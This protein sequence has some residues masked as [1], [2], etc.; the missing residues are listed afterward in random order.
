VQLHHFIFFL[1][2]P[3]LACAPSSDLSQAIKRLDQADL[4]INSRQNQF[5]RK[6]EDLSNSVLVLQDRVETLKVALER[7]PLHETTTAPVAAAHPKPQPARSGARPGSARQ[8]DAFLPEAAKTAKLPTIKLTNKDLARMDQIV[9]PA[10]VP[11]A[12]TS[13]SPTPSKVTSEDLKAAEEYNGAYVVFEQEKYAE[14]IERFERFTK[15]YP[16][17]SYADNAVFWVGEAYFR[18]A[19]YGKAKANFDRVVREFPTGNKIPDAL[20]KSGMCELR[21]SDAEGAR[22]TF[23]KIVDEYPQSIAAQK[24]KTVLAELS[25]LASQGRM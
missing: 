6:V 3:F 9:G 15:K 4:A 22:L 13:N 12:A 14:A 20:L 2:V 25:N 8:E 1:T 19:D 11:A 21:L 7:K 10:A 16:A 18:M 24:A 23:N 5:N 17:H